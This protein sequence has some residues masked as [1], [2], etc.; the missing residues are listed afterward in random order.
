MTISEKYKTQH[1]FLL[2]GE[3][4]L[5]N[6]V[7]AQL[8]LANQ[9]NV[10]MLFSKHTKDIADYLKKALKRLQIQ[11][12]EVPLGELEVDGC[13]IARILREEV[14]NFN[15][16][17]TIGLHYTGGTKTMAAHAYR[18]LLNLSRTQEPIFSYLDSRGFQL[19][20]DDLHNQ[21]T[22]KFS[23]ALEVNPPP[24][25]ETILGLHNLKWKPGKEPQNQSTAKEAAIAFAEFHGKADV[26]RTWRNWCNDVLYTLKQSRGE[27]SRWKDE[28]TLNNQSKLKIDTLPN[29]IIQV[30]RDHLESSVTEL[31]LKSLKQKYPFPTLESICQWLDGVWLEDYVLQQVQNISDKFCLRESVMSLRIQ[32]PNKPNRRTDQFEFDVAFLRG[33]QLFG[34]SCT[35]S[36]SHARC[37]QKL[38][39]A[40]LRAR[41][42]GGDEARIALV[43]ANSDTEQVK[44]LK[45][46]VSLAISDRKI[47]VFGREDLVPA[48]FSKKLT[49]WIQQ[50]I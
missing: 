8:L 16:E 5:P 15:P 50:N 13:A 42:L 7:A 4:P 34:I 37:K 30:L 3:N 48:K 33:Y 49:S 32:D 23:V 2:I 20:I 10:Y 18:A 45:Q 31:D 29:L 14:D 12:K 17:E 19:C 24:S 39:E 1:L 38:F 40:I 21:N 27:N 9:G 28:T 43:S 11:V 22:L 47:E 44:W 6:Y 26:G 35:T 36:L 25:L 41:Q 46:E